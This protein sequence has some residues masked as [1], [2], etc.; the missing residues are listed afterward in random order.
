MPKIQWVETSPAATGGS[1]KAPVWHLD[2]SQLATEADFLDGG[3]QK[4]SEVGVTR[5]N[6]PFDS[7]LVLIFASQKA[8]KHRNGWTPPEDFESILYKDLNGQFFCDY[9]FDESDDVMRSHL[10]WTCFKIKLVDD[11]LTKYQW[12]QTTVL[13]KWD[14]AEQKMQVF[15]IDLADLSNDPKPDH[16]FNQPQFIRNNIPKSQKQ[17]MHPFTWHALLAKSCIHLYDVSVWKLRDLVRPV[18]QKRDHPTNPSTA[19]PQLHDISRHIFHSTETLEV[20]QNTVRSLIAENQ[21]FQKDYEEWNGKGHRHILDGVSSLLL[22][23]ERE[24]HSQRA[25]SNSLAERLHNEI[26]LAFNLVTL[27]ENN[28]LKT[29]GVVSMVYLPGT[30]V[31]GIFGTNFFDFNAPSENTWTTSG[32]FYLYWAVTVPLTVV[33]FLVWALWHGWAPAMTRWEER[34]MKKQGVVKRS[35]TA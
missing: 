1:L 14:I 23:L 17:R 15:F 25:R 28:V 19:L 22:Y 12:I 16:R 2:T 3:Q 34:R 20:S 18:E 32:N 26:N 10:S 13:V 35:V 5:L 11:P 8:L 31:S 24:M 7:E 30:F 33:T 27:G 4:R 6:E 9:V 29:L 21:R